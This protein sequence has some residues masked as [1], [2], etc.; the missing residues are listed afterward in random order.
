M[1]ASEH[2]D[3]PRIQPDHLLPVD[4]DPVEAYAWARVL[5]RQGFRISALACHA[6]DPADAVIVVGMTAD[7]PMLA[8][9]LRRQTTVLAILTI[10]EPQQSGPADRILVTPVDANDLA[11]HVRRLPGWPGAVAPGISTPRVPQYS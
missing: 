6:S 5:E 7:L 10:V 2:A 8:A 4:A 9:T 11:T 3:R 1:K